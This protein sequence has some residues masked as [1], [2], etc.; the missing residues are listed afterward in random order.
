VRNMGNLAIIYIAGLSEGIHEPMLGGASAFDRVLE[1]GRSVPE[2]RG[3]R[4]LADASQNVP[5]GLTVL[6]RE[7]WTEESL[8]GALAEIV[9]AFEDAD[10]PE[11]LFYAWGDSPLMDSKV[12]D[13]LW[14]LHYRY[15]A[16]YTF[17]DGYPEGLAPEI[18]AAALPGKLRALARD[19]QGSPARNSLFEI[20]RQDINAF[21]VETD[22]SPVDLRMDRVS[23]TCDT[24]RN[25]S[26]TEKLHAAGGRDAESLCR[27]I[28]EHRELLRDRP[29]FFPIQVTDRAPQ[30]PSY[31]PHAA[32][33]GDPRQGSRHMDVEL[34]ADL[35]RRIAEFAGDA[36]VSPSLIGE[37]ASHPRIG[38]LIRAALQPP[39]LQV[40]LET[41]GIGWDPDLLESLAAEHGDGRLKW[42]VTLDAA[43]PELYRS[44]RGEGQAAAEEGARRLIALFGRHCWIQAVRMNENEEHL[45]DFYRTWT[46][47]GAQVIIQKFD[48]Y[49]GFLPD[50]QPADLS[51]LDRFPCWHIKRDMPILIDGRV[52]PCVD[53]LERREILGNVFEEELETVWSAGEALHRSH[54]EG[55]YPGPC[56]KCDEYYTFNF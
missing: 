33:Y 26:I 54:V 55:D 2:S 45:E 4:V 16:E 41:S 52:P 35:C 1:W 27:V 36:V 49:A 48:S 30:A 7:E 19:R 13:T 29:A 56:A 22:L 31:R 38:D 9:E 11:A 47:E 44:L 50:R 37:P 32:V 51:P 10:R 46:D 14:T 20:L 42:I 21:D 8:V 3:I 5:D 12:T 43:D 23:I 39:S 53:D 17:A 18:L 6:R 40:L 24:R 15:D 34:F 25:R 28:P